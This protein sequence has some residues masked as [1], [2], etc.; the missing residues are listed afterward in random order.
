MPSVVTKY[1]VLAEL[2]IC[3]DLR[4]MGKSERTGGQESLHT[5]AVQQ[6]TNVRLHKFPDKYVT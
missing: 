3:H 6:A 5:A 2:G 4:N 1:R